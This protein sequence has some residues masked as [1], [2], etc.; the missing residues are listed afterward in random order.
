MDSVLLVIH[1]IVAL[2]LIA[3]VLLQRSEGGALGMGGG[4]GGG[5]GFL[6]GRGAAN[7]LTRTTAILTVAFFATSILLTLLARQ[8]SAPSTILDQAGEQSQ[9]TTPSAPSS[10]V[11]PQL[12]A[13]PSSTPEPAAPSNN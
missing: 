12:P 1:L 6:S 2:C 5:G 10:S 7:A 4:G 3:T 8:D 9:G 13:S 11:L